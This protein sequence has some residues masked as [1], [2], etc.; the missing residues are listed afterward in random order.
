[1][2]KNWTIA[3]IVLVVIVVI[4]GFFMLNK[5]AP[6]T[7]VVPPSTGMQTHAVNIANMA[8]SPDSLTIKVGDMVVWTN[9]DTVNHLL[10]GSGGIKSMILKPG[11]TYSQ[12]FN[13]TGTW[14]YHCE[15]HPSMK[16][17]IIVE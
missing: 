17:T 10:G 15:I 14:A 13:N 2:N 4:A 3:I 1:M 5:P 6:V 7:P 16:G 8:F 12:T 9:S 11:D